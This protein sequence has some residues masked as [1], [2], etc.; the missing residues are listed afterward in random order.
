MPPD[1]GQV[2][3]T[4]QWVTIAV[5][6]AGTFGGMGFARFDT[7]DYLNDKNPTKAKNVMRAMMKMRK[8]D[9]NRIKQ[10]YREK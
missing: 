1:A 7:H 2:N 4:F 3:A 5:R 6:L 9:V 10:A 8:I